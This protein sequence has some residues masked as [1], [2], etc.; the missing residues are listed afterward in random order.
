MRSDDEL[1]AD[2]LAGDPAAFDELMIRHGDSI[3]FYLTGYLRNAEDAEDLMIDAF[4]RIMVKR[5]RIGQ[6]CFRAYLYKTARNLAS[7]HRARSVKRAEFSTDGMEELLSDGG[8]V[9]NAFREKER[10]G[11]LYRCLDRIDPRLRE[12]LWLVYSEGMSYAEAA[13]VRGTT[14]KKVDKLLSRAKKQMREELG[15]EGITNAYE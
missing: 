9:E 15:K 10:D 13:G 4:A 12:A 3:V 14:E 8:S 5:P 1:Y 6:G 11:A 2:Y 7:R